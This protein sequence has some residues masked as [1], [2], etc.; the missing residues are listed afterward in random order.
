MAT[1]NMSFGIFKHRLKLVTL[2][3]LGS[4]SFVSLAMLQPTLYFFL[5][6]TCSKPFWI[7]PFLTWWLPQSQHDALQIWSFLQSSFLRHLLPWQQHFQLPCTVMKSG[8]H[9]LKI[10]HQ[11]FFQQAELYLDFV[12]H[13][14]GFT[15]KIVILVLTRF[16]LS[17]YDSFNFNQFP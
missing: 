14:D 2:R 8:V 3:C 15:S 5:F 6:C 4:S 10:L 7:Q 1:L 13:F 17:K 11:R 12:I 9:H 16:C